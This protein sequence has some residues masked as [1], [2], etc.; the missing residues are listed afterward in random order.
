MLRIPSLLLILAS[1]TGGAGQ[2]LPT[3]FSFKSLLL[4]TQSICPTSK[5]RRATP[6]AL[7]DVEE[8]FRNRLP[9]AQKEIL[10]PAIPRAADGTPQQCA[11]RN[12]D[13]QAG[14]ELDAIWRAGL[15][16]EF[17][18]AVCARGSAPWR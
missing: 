14:A 16:H 5:V 18:G 15:M 9:H 1:L 3:S 8:G 7:L 13:C 2:K 10:R 4:E 11:G 17:A 12:T 6:A